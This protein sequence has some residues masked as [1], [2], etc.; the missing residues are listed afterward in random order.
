MVSDGC[1]G[2]WWAEAIFPAITQCC[3]AHDFG[4]SNGS[5]L[6]CLEGVLPDWAYP[7]AGI[8]VAVMIVFRPLYHLVKKG[9]TR[10]G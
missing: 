5:L 6:D 8:C 9:F 10:R 3:A 2:F 1:T 4:A 7:L